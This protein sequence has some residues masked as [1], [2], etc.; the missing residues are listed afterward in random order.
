MLDRPHPTGGNDFRHPSISQRSLIVGR[1]GSG[2]TQFGAW[3]LS[4]TH[5]DKMPYFIVDYKGDELLAAP[6]RI[7]EIGLHEK[8]PDK[9][10][11]YI[12]HP[13][14]HQEEEVERWLW[15]I[16]SQTHNGLYVDEGY[17]LPKPGNAFRALLT[18]GR[19]RKIP[20]T[21][22]S[23]RPVELDRYAVSESDFYTIFHLNDIDDRKTV[24]RF[25][26]KTLAHCRLPKF[27]SAWYD[28][29]QDRSLI[30]SPVPGQDVIV[31]R[32]EDRL[33]PGKR[34]WI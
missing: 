3:Q 31:E 2:K 8:L 13:L 28:V 27:H 33:K 21:V 4:R 19:S 20:V 15:K 23:Q 9:P 30:V 1:T 29:A 34:V 11:L 17:F 22:L 16:W 18:T 12:V 25:V 6:T 26:P 32:I 7:K 24:G 10:G 5:F 14:P